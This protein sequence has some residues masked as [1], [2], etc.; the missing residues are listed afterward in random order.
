[1]EAIADVCGKGEAKDATAVTN[2]KV[3]GFRCNLFGGD[4]QVPL[5]FAQLIINKDDHAPGLEV[6][7]GFVDAGKVLRHECSSRGSATAAKQDRRER[8]NRTSLLYRA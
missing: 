1:M 3:Y 5:V 6:R 8:R 2:H 4:D 7:Q